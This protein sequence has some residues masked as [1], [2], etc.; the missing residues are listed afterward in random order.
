[1][2]AGEEYKVEDVVPIKHVHGVSEN[3]VAIKLDNNMVT[4]NGA[5][6]KRSILD[7]TLGQEMQ[8]TAYNIM[9]YATRRKRK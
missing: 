8:Y 3:V 5:K 6:N 4:V 2:P 9:E 7:I 1:M